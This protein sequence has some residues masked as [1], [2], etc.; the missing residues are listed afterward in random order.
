MRCPV[1]HRRLTVG[2]ACPVHGQRPSPGPPAEPLPLPD[3]PGLT[4]AALLGKGG[5]SH[6]FT[7][8]R[9][10]DGREVAL[11]LGLGSHH[12]R[13]AREAAALRRLGPPTAPELLQHGTTRGRPFLVLEHLHGQTLAAWMAALPGTGAASVPRVRE[14]LSGLC[15][16]VERVHAAGLAHR[17]L[18]PENIFLREGGALSLLDLGLA[19]FL[20]EPGEG[21][22]P[23]AELPG[24]TP[25]GQRLGTPIYM[26][27][28]QCLDAREAGAAADIY[29][30]GVLLF[31]LLTGAPPFTGGSEEIR[32]GHVSLRPPR[33]SER[34]SVPAALDEVLRRCLAKSP[35]E[36][37]ARASEV[38]SAF[39]VACREGVRATE[40]S[41]SVVAPMAVLPGSGTGLRPVALLG[42]PAKLTVDALLAAV[43]PH[44]GTLAR[45]WPH[46]YVVAFSESHSAEANLRA[47][48]LVARRLAEE[49]RAGAVLHLAELHVYP[50]ATTTRVAG[51]ALEALADWWP[52]DLAVGEACVTPA[53]AARLGPGATETSAAGA[54]R[55]RDESLR[56]RLHDGGA[57]TSSSE[58]PPLAGRDVVVDALVAEAVLCLGDG[59]PGFCVL[60]GE[61][62]HGKSRV[63]E[64]LAA[65]LEGEGRARVVRLRAA[66]PDAVTQE[67]LHDALMAA[68]SSQGGAL[69]RG[70]PATSVS[71]ERTASLAGLEATPLLLRQ[72]GSPPLADVR[73]AT[74]RALAEE[75]RH[76][77]RQAPLVLLVD[78]GHLADPTS[79][80]ALEVATLAGTRAPLWVCI[81]A[82]PALLGLRPHLGE[83]SARVSHYALPPLSPEASR[84]LLLRLLLPAEHIPEPVLARLEQLAQGVP[85]SLVELAGALRAA[86]ALRTSPGGGWYVAPDALLDVSITPLFERLAARALAGLPEAHR[87][88]ARL[89]AVLGTEVE[90]ARVDA[91]LRHLDLNEET[92]RVASLDAGAGLHRLARTGLLRSAGAGR[93][94]FRHPLLREA[95]E[96]LLPPPTRRALHAAALRA[97]PT[98]GLAER[99]R[100]AHHA[101]A[102]GAH[103]EATATFLALAEEARRAHL[104]VEAEQ[105][106]TRALAL[107]PDGDGERRARAL[108]GR[109][110]V[111]HRLQRFREGLADLAAARVLAEARKDVAL[112]VDL[113]LEEATA[114]DWM[115]DVDGSAACTREALERIEQLDDPRLSLRCTLARGRLHVRQGE[116]GAAARVL[117]SAVE[118]AERAR[119]HETLVVAG[120]L[121]G[122][123]LTFLDRTE[124]AATRFDE[125]LTRCEET[126]DA[127]HLAA[128]LINRVLLWLRLGDVGRMEEDLRRAM[129]LGRELGHAQ[130]E[131]WS[132]FNLAEVLYMQGRLEEALPLARRVHEL[133]VRFFRE[134]PVPV[135][136]LL[137][138]RIGAALGDLAEAARQLRW[139]ESHCPP[140]S[141]PPTAVM[142]RLVELQVREDSPG[143]AAP[144]AQAWQALAEDADTYASADEKA[145]I[146]L[147][148]ARGALQSGRTREARD[149][150]ERAERAVEGAPL[151]RPRLE[152]LR[153]SLWAV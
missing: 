100:R 72:K 150:L 79:L 127:L 42:V 2:A 7:A 1:C 33:V 19:R 18:K 81:A 13:F 60:T 69:P 80:D 113:L 87:V 103:A 49:G 119:D 85:L 109:G 132:T 3:V 128:T 24:F 110:R 137:L 108:A 104:S 117:T 98:E 20:D 76:H 35:T 45:V 151:W 51:A 122:S 62:G 21:V 126:G 145:E 135:D 58:A 116:W 29:A 96:A 153:A 61:V 112:Q 26:S 15:A 47:G 146:L 114:R 83:R 66:S 131:R 124:E 86:G 23:D 11:K 71:A 32:H 92:E 34:A 140:E 78:D 36:R 118:G 5:F 121:L 84:A 17:D 39:D 46:G 152:S 27:P 54:S 64:A 142:R 52:E 91:A 16:A 25:V 9:E 63:M 73:H 57:S 38:L 50:G 40:P 106:Y 30:L 95:L 65:R 125:A 43:E 143:S 102:C 139:I 101:A 93:F 148:A 12:E 53:A 141:L 107:L 147:Q 144:D 130:V 74:A 90:V 59:V 123:A 55:P 105:H 28:E 97:T 138:A 136:A 77:A 6:V 70:G 67:P 37:Y 89:C 22:A 88:L 111:R 41:P 82:R 56:L 94:A 8:Y 31:E 115:E 120:A 129:A 99:R 68:I 44:G 10:E 149:W 134:H 4:S 48:A 133:G 14:L 75:L